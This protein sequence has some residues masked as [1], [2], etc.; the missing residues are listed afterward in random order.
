M[1][2]IVSALHPAAL[3]EISKML[4]HAARVRYASRQVIV[5]AGETPTSL[6][7]I[8]AGSVTVLTEDRDGEEFIL[9]YLGPGEFFGELGFFDATLARSASV[10]ARSKCEVAAIGYDRFRS[11]IEQ[12]PA[13]LMQLATQVAYR[14]RDAS[15]N[16][17]SLAFLDVKGRIARILLD[18]AHDSEAITH[19]DGMLVRV[20]REELGRLVNC[21]REMA[22]RVLVDLQQ[23]GLI[24]VEGKSIVIRD[25]Q[26]TR[27]SP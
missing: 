25:P 14:L 2:A 5:R 26:A 19:P 13:L 3:P 12:T 27:R 8:L 21:S 16:L 20:S 17:G 1:V 22:S 6:Y 11:L 7:F 9:S 15:A 23:Q 24:A 10:R 4:E 18:L